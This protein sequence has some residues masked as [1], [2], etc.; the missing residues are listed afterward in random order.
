MS[1]TGGADHEQEL[2]RLLDELGQTLGRRERLLE[3]MKR[4]RTQARLHEITV[5]AEQPF[6]Q[7]DQEALVGDLQRE[8]DQQRARDKDLERVLE[9]LRRQREIEDRFFRELDPHIAPEHRND[10]AEL[11]SRM[12][13]RDG[14]FE[15]I[16]SG[17]IEEKWRLVPEVMDSLQELEKPAL[18]AHREP[19]PKAASDPMAQGRRDNREQ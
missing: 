10:L 14:I 3:G 6:E 1:E 2:T 17:S 16:D 18:Q 19:P 5:E 4:T 7:L 15:N 11:E 12:D 13:A 9:L 8:R